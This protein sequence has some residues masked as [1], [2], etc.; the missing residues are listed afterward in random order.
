ML[1][2]TVLLGAVL[3]GAGPAARETQAELRDRI[4]LG[5]LTELRSAGGLLSVTLRAAPQQIAIGAAGFPGAAYNGEYAGPVLH[6]RPG[7]L[8]HI[9]LVNALADPTNLH[10]H[11]LRVSPL[12]RGDNM[13]IVVAPGAA[14]DYVF[15]IPADHPPGLYW[16]HDHLHHMAERHVT[17]GLSGTI[18]IDGFASQFGGLA[19]LPQKLLVLKDYAN[20][21][22]TGDVLKTQLHCRVL[23]INGRESWHATMRPGE[24]Q[25]WRLVNEGANLTLHLAAPGLRLR[26]VGRDGTP[27]TAAQDTGTID[28]MPASRLDVL[29]TAG[30]PGAITLSALHVLT[31][32]GAALAVNR[33]MGGITVAG[34]PA[35]AAPALTFPAQLDLRTLPLDAQRVFTFTEKE[36][37]GEYYIDGKRFDHDRIDVRVPLGHVES[38]T[39][40]NQTEDFHEFHIHQLG[41]QVAAI[42]GRQQAFSGYVDDVDVP[43]MGAVTLIL[44]FT[45]PNM[46]GH[47]MFH[48]HVLK[49]EDGGMMANIEVYRPGTPARPPICLFPKT[50]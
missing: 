26:V 38:W 3:G 40:R 5:G 43:P 8:V 45:D 37:A 7:D 27:A 46:V 4:D 20:P 1:A 18:L 39:I 21:D 36:D 22:C 41:F 15:R 30:A 47:F 19:D 16:Y 44:P 48:C 6:V 35:A 17:S 13:H 33:P 49:H 28:I 50:R 2:G 25:L 29:A 34:T 10:F 42:N 9:R 32:A 23:S 11:G 12:N 24:T 14:Q 31:G